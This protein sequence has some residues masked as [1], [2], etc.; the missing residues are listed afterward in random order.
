MPALSAFMEAYP[1]INL[2]LD[3]TDRLVDVIEEGFD[4]VIRTG[5]I[6]DTRLVRRKLGTFRHRIVASPA[7]L[8]AHGCPK[9]PEETPRG[10]CPA[11]L[12]APSLRTLWQA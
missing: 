1:E 5:D 4:A 9:R 12:S 2:D 10:S 7:Y 6:R 11:P 3:F 8:N